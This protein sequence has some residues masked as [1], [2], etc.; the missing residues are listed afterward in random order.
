MGAMALKAPSNEPM[1]LYTKLRKTAAIAPRLSR[2]HILSMF[3]Q[4]IRA[5]EALRLIDSGLA[6]RASVKLIYPAVKVFQPFNRCPGPFVRAH[7][8]PVGKIRDGEFIARQI[9]SLG[10]PAVQN[11]KQPAT[12][13]LVAINSR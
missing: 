7:P 1:T 8:T 12:F 6:T 11:L 5:F 2:H 4:L 10:Q 3:Y 13:L 9:A